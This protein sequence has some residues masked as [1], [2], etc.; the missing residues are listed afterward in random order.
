L[1][2]FYITPSAESTTFNPDDVPGIESDN[3]FDV[4]VELEGRVQAGRMEKEISGTTVTAIHNFAQLPIANVFEYTSTNF[5]TTL[6]NAGLANAKFVG[7]DEKLT[8][9]DQLDPSLVT[10]SDT[11]DENQ[12]TITL[13]SSINGRLVLLG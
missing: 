5:S 13:G 3:L 1:T 6:A 12:T 4:I 11:I 2:S 9:L 7:A 10:R 8:G